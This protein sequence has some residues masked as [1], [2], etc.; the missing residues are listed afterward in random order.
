MTRSNSAKDIVWEDFEL[1]FYITVPNTATWSRKT[2][3]QQIANTP[4]NSINVVA[5]QNWVVSI[6]TETEKNYNK[7]NI[8]AECR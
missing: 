5:F 3:Q 7:A 2:P 8:T 4:S 1:K 6:I